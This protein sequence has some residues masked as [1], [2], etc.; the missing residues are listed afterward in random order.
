M[1]GEGGMPCL[2][3]EGGGAAFESRSVRPDPGPEGYVCLQP[4]EVPGIEVCVCNIN[5]E[6]CM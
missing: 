5:E 6:T 3:G 4:D 1:G 2:G